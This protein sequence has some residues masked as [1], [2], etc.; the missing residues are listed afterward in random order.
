MVI[1]HQ[2]VTNPAASRAPTGEEIGLCIEQ[3]D[4]HGETAAARALI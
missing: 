2:L 1:H 3:V 4:G